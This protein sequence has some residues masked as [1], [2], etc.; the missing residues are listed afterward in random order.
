M[1]LHHLIYSL[2]DRVNVSPLPRQRGE[3]P[4]GVPPLP[5]PVG[6]VSG[7]LGGVWGEDSC[8]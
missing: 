4:E 8:H 5:F 7:L 1:Y 6:A 2:N 3:H